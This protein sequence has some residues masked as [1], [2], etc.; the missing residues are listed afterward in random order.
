[1]PTKPRQASW[2]KRRSGTRSIA[3]RIELL[4]AICPAN[5][6]AV[7]VRMRCS[8]TCR[9]DLQV[10]G[11]EGRER[12]VGAPAD[13]R[14]AEVE[15]EEARPRAE[16]QR[17]A[18][19]L[20]QRHGGGSGRRGEPQQARDRQRRAREGEAVDEREGGPAGETREERSAEQEGAD[21]EAARQRVVGGEEA[22]AHLDGE[23]RR[24]PGQ[25]RRGAEGAQQ[26][27]AEHAADEE[28]GHPGG[29]PRGCG[30]REAEGDQQEQRAD[31][32]AHHHLPLVAEA[33]E[34]RGGEHLHREHQVEERRGEPDLERAR[35]ERLGEQHHRG[36]EADHPGEAV[37]DAEGEARAERAQ[38]GA[39][40]GSTST[41]SPG[42]TAP[43][44]STLA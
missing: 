38:A 2:K 18:R 41:S 21:A 39:A 6:A 44:V 30:E 17:F 23:D 24:H 43:G 3:A 4:P 29:R 27:E 28:V 34:A 25:V 32:P 1:M 5:C 9:L 33:R 42:L 12:G 26:A 31:P 37:E 35:A 19:Q 11:D 15:A 13:E 16:A 36:A 20:A 40:Q 22:P 7:K 8:G 14:E 10:V